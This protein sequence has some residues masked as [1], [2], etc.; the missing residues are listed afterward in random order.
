MSSIHAVRR[1]V[2]VQS[3]AVTPSKEFSYLVVSAIVDYQGCATSINYLVS[4]TKLCKMSQESRNSSTAQTRGRKGATSARYQN[5]NSEIG[6]LRE[7]EG[8]RTK[9]EPKLS[10]QN[11]AN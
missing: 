7:E 9:G 1:S 2:R 8:T 5:P 11:A 6:D 3:Q 4:E 10:K